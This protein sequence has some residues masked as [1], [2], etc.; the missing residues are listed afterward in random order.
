V[1]AELLFCIRHHLAGAAAMHK[2]GKSTE[3]RGF[4]DKQKQS[5]CKWMVNM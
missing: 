3:G 4:I 1:D 2:G 5:V